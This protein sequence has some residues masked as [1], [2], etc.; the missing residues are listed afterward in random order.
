MSSKQLEPV[1]NSLDY[2][3]LLYYFLLL[4]LVTRLPFILMHVQCTSMKSNIN[5]HYEDM[6]YFTA[7]RWLNNS[8]TRKKFFNLRR[9]IYELCKEK[10]SDFKELLDSAWLCDFTFFVHNTG[11]IISLNLKLQAKNKLALNSQCFMMIA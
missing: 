7:V 3:R 11:I 6:V 4:A 5:F 10:N 8:F 1:K 2:K 9:K